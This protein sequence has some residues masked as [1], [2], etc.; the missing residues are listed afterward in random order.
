MSEESKQ[1]LRSAQCARIIV[2]ISDMFGV[3]SI[4]ILKPQT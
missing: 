3:S 2:C 1:V 4:I